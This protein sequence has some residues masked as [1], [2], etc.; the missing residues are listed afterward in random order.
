MAADETLR[1]SGLEG[2]T[3]CLLRTGSV[4]EIA[5][6]RATSDKTVEELESGVIRVGECLCGR[7]AEDGVPLILHSKKEVLEYATRDSQRGE[8]IRFHAAF[9]M[10]VESRCIGVLCVFT[11]TDKK[12]SERSLK[13]LETATKQIAIAIERARLFE[14]V[15]QSAEELEQRVAQRTL[16]L[17][18]ANKELES[19]S[20]SV[21]HDLRAP[22]RAIDGFSL[23]VLEDYSEKLDD[24]GQRYLN[25]I[26]SAAV[27]MGQLI[28]DILRLSRVTRAEMNLGRID[29]SKI[30]ESIAADLTESHPERKVEFVIES[31][32]VTEADA[33][34]MKIALEN[35]IGNAWKFTGGREI[36]RIEF[37]AIQK[38]GKPAYYVKDNGAGFDPAYMDKLF[39]AFQRLHSDVE[40]P[41][42]GIGLATVKRI[43]QRH[44]G[45]VW[46]EGEVDKGATFYFTLGNGE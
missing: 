45:E 19:F 42:T 18:N 4:L 25:R 35:L 10:M 23:V 44:G 1:I 36:A 21:S 14:E 38:N 43:I 15:K 8:D 22:L 28:D 5:A 41:G 3:I 7:C 31:G 13:L 40:F 30:A 29:L 9:P 46:A 16:Q 17:E 11:R 33:N 26:R 6:H 20:Y 37:G 39:I 24:E 32:L 27:R 2:S 34:L 12:P